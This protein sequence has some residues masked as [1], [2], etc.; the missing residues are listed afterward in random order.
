MCGGM[1][2]RAAAVSR[3][4]CG[5]WLCLLV[6]L[7]LDVV[8]V[9]CDQDPLDPV[10]LP[11]AL[12]L[13][14][15][16]EHFRVQQVGRYPPAN[17]SL[18]SRSET[19]LLLQPW[20]R[21]QPLLRA[22]Y[23]PFATQQ[24][25]PPRVTEPHQRPVPWDVRAV[26]V[27]GAVTPAEP[28]ARVLFHLK[29]QDWPPGPGSLPCA[30]LHATHPAGT[31]HRACHFQPSLGACVV[32][33]EFPSHWF[34]QGSTTRAELAYTLEP[35]AEG[36]G[37]CG[38]GREEDP[39]EQALPVGGVELRPA[40]PPQY[41][42]VPLDEAVTLRV[43]DV[44]VRP[45]QLFSAT[46]LL[47]HN[48]TASVLTLRIKVKKGLHVTAAR[49]AQPS[50]W[51]AKL[52]RF[53]GSKHH[54]TLITC[55]RAGPSGP[56]SSPLEQSEFLWVDF[57]VENG[58]SG[59]VAVTRPVTWQLE[60]AGQAPEAEKDKMVWEILVSERDVRALVPLAKAEELVNT[61]PLTGEARRVPVRLVTVD[62]G[63]AL[64]EV[65]EQIGCES[66]NTQVLQVSGMCQPRVS[67]RSCAQ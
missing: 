51:T 30:R 38:P 58:T 64:V 48:F 16:P 65:T 14:D 6:A 4:P 26:S 8:R 25:V 63:G 50:L 15:A 59:G 42:E 3:G 31:A 62:S 55:H 29:G 12:E 49:P 36:P 67:M 2:G 37:G 53:K 7:A 21:A 10:Y 52:D 11:A 27:E 66:A 57:L 56:D 35:A 40:D 18:G 32:E 24:V 23:P 20:P 43:P 39:R 46:L 19:F 13:L 28:H 1:A 41:Q 34:S 45:G 54:T 17:S 61:A 44:P 22:S 9:G 33:L 60:Y 47:R 5:P